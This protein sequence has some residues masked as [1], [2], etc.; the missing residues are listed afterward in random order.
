MYNVIKIIILD[1]FKDR[2]TIKNDKNISYF[3]I[4][5]KYSRCSRMIKHLTFT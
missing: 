2:L 4:R 3:I 1:I 5:Q